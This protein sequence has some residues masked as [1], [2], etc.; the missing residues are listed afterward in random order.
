MS[1]VMC[2]DLETRDIMWVIGDN[3]W[4]STW[5]QRASTWAAS[6]AGQYADEAL[7]KVK[8]TEEAML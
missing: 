3:D 4:R 8:A 7:A 5:P 6:F 1:F 2:S